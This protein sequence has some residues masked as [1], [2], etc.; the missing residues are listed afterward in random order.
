MTCKYLVSLNIWI[1]FPVLKQYKWTISH[2]GMNEMISNSLTTLFKCLTMIRYLWNSVNRF[3][4]VSIKEITALSLAKLP[5]YEKKIFY[6]GKKIRLTRININN[7]Q[8]KPLHEKINIKKI[9]K[10]QK[11]SREN[12][13]KNWVKRNQIFLFLKLINR[14]S[15][16]TKLF[17]K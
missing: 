9:E 11:K 15:H 1:F 5:N 6:C 2:Y 7:I 14:M 16:S 13:Q 12:I 8:I 10:S 17:E 3:N 4:I